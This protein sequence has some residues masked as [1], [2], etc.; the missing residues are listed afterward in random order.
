MIKPKRWITARTCLASI[1]VLVAIDGD[2]VGQVAP[3]NTASE[4]PW[5]SRIDEVTLQLMRDAVLLSDAQAAHV[6]RLY[7]EHERAF[8][9]FVEDGQAQADAFKTA[10]QDA[11]S[12]LDRVDLRLEREIVLAEYADRQARLDDAFLE[13][14][15]GSLAEV[16]WPAWTSF[17]RRL[18]RDR[19]IGYAGVYAEED[20][21]LIA[22]VEELLPS[23]DP[24]WNDPEFA[25]LISAYA[26]ELD[27]ALRDR[28]A[29]FIAGSR[30]MERDRGWATDGERVWVEPGSHLTPKGRSARRALM[31]QHE[32]VRNINQR[33]FSQILAALPDPFRG[34]FSLAYRNSTVGVAVGRNESAATMDQ[35]LNQILNLDHLADE[36]RE[37]IQ[38]E[39]GGDLQR[40][41]LA[42]R[43]VVRAHD[44]DAELSLDYMATSA[45]KDRANE[46]FRESVDALHQL[47]QRFVTQ[48]WNM[49]N[50][51]QRQLISRPALAHD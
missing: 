43:E 36:Q 33:Y 31:R 17:I 42:A 32:R 21:D 7:E 27:R 18:D 9:R 14:V 38:A 23:D 48:T 4:I 8:A 45:D 29:L 10:M 39:I 6:Q 46:T 28:Y 15:K 51:T 26:A 12:E 2:A 11:G 30:R 50:E 49:L 5:Q 40:F 47:D 35:F 16:Q 20:V 3:W 25:E 24:H 37:A 22:K 44:K 19:W 41:E 13:Q 1:A 34:R